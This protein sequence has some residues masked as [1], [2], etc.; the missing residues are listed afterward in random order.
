MLNP[1]EYITCWVR[2]CKS[3][4][5]PTSP[6]PLIECDQSSV[7]LIRCQPRFVSL[8]FFLE[9]AERHWNGFTVFFLRDS[10]ISFGFAFDG[11]L[12]R[13]C[14]STLNFDLCFFRFSDRSLQMDG[15]RNCWRAEHLLCS[16]F[17]LSFECDAIPSRRLIVFAELAKVIWKISH[18]FRSVVC[19]GCV[20]WI[21]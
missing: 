21:R 17:T 15:C 14:C 10:H 5:S 12:A 4:H 1:N 6:S 8:H 18:D 13:C 19:D 11:S 9:R 16:I 20:R 7:E 3:L 2:Q